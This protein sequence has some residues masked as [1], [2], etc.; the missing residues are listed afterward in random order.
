[1]APDFRR[2]IEALAAENVRFVIVGGVAMVLHGSTRVTQDLDVRYT[3]DDANL[4]AMVRALSPL[5]AAL[6]RI[7][8]FASTRERCGRA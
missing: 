3:R 1:V 6:R 8:R 4:E 7:S 2:L 5:G